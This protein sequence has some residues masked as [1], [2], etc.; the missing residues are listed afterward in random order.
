MQEVAARSPSDR[1]RV[2]R[3]KSPQRSKVANGSAFLPECQDGRSSWIRRAK[4]LLSDLLNGQL[5]GAGNYSEAEAILAKR[6]ACLIVELE[7]RESIFAKAGAAD[8]T[9]LAIY[10][11]TVNTLRRTLET[12]GIERR[13]RNVTPT[14]ADYIRHVK[15]AEATE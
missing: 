6:A 14:V 12:I 5:G 2:A 9:A 11:T 7:R 4:E 15:Q 3:P 1:Q 8:D 10:Q 13:S